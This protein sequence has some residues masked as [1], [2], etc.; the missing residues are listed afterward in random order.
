MKIELGDFIEFD[1][2]FGQ[3]K[4]YISNQGTLNGYYKGVIED[5]ISFET[6]QIYKIKVGP[7]KFC[8]VRE[9]GIKRA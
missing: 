5:I 3:T 2:T 4:E 8:Y 7:N 9:E 1:F 6:R